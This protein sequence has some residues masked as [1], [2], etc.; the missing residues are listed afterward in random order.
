M[1]KNYSSASTWIAV[2]ADVLPDEEEFEVS[3]LVVDLFLSVDGFAA[4]EGVGPFFGYAG[5]ELDDWVRTELAV[6]QTLLMGRITYLAMAQMTSSAGDEISVRMTD[7][8]KIVVSNTLDDCPGWA[9]TEVLRGSLADGIRDI[10]KDSSHR[11]RSMGSISLVTSLMQLGLVD[12][13]RLMIFPIVV[14]GDG[15]DPAF[16]GHPRAGMELASTTVLDGRLVLLDYR[17]CT[18]HG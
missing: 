8:R 2:Q 7:L 16:P 14:G 1:A 15:R 5:P 3:E 9:N 18:R 11:L 17:L 13:L 6:P 12:R 4:G 10:K